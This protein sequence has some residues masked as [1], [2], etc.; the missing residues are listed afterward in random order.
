MGS[1]SI[2]VLAFN[3]RQYLERCI[4]AVLAQTYPDIELIVMDNGSNDGSVELVR[5]E[6]PGM[7]VVENSSNL[8]Y[9]GGHNR[10]IRMSESDFFIPLNPDLYMEPN[11]VGEA[12][13]AFQM[14]DRVGIVTGKLYQLGESSGQQQRLDS[15]GLVVSKARRNRDRGFGE[16]DRGQY[17]RPEYVFGASGSAPVYRRAMLED[18]KIDEEY[19]DEDMFAYREEVDIA[20]RAHLRGW[21]ALYVPTVMGY[22]VRGYSPIKRKSLPRLNRRLHFQN[23]YLMMIKCDSWTNMLRHAPHILGFEILALGYVFLR[24]PHLL[25]GYRDALRLLPRM[26]RK[27][28][29]VRSRKLVPDSDLL[30]WFV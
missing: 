28:R 16:V 7:T 27:R 13:K 19:F 4:E 25:L 15:A 12:V 26:I 11:F 6:F 30:K 29:I 20:W 18:I 5:E 23:R 8:G 1:V 22:H 24:E 14:D 9:A 3:H 21:R 17:D 10:A 2:N